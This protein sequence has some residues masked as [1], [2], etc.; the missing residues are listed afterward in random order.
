[1]AIVLKISG[2]L[3][4]ELYSNEKCICLCSYLFGQCGV[5]QI[6]G[7]ADDIDIICVKYEDLLNMKTYKALYQFS[8]K[9]ITTLSSKY[10]KSLLSDKTISSV[11][12]DLI[13]EFYEMYL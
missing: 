9:Y 8:H 2:E 6:I 3:I 11:I 12:K 13:N 4:H 10:Y 7:Y 5:Y 1:M